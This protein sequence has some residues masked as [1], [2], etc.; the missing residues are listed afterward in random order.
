MSRPQW[1]HGFHTGRAEG[2][3]FGQQ[4][5]EAR[6]EAEIGMYVLSAVTAAVRAF[7]QRR[8][9]ESILLLRLLRGYLE[10]RMGGPLLPEA[11]EKSPP[12]RDSGLASLGE[13]AAGGGER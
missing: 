6:A 11:D 1:G 2:Q 10:D 5:G 9:L 4:I 7:E 12:E 13:R 8:E 3:K